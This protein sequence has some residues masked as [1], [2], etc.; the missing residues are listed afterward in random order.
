MRTKDSAIK[1]AKKYLLMAQGLNIK[2]E[3]AFL[4]GSYSKDA[5][6][7]YSD[8]DLAIVSKDF[9]ENPLENW[10][11]VA[12]ASIK[13][14]LIEPHLFTWQEYKKSNSFLMEEVLKNGIEIKVP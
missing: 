12:L 8:I 14:N 7:N 2:I 9:G 10:K 5:Q 11:M 6:T 1:Y 13:Y 3:K 4:F